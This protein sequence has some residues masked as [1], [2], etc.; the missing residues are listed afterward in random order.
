MSRERF[1]FR[2]FISNDENGWESGAMVAY[3][4][5]DMGIRL[6]GKR[7][8]SKKTSNARTNITT[9]L[10]DTEIKWTGERRGLYHQ[11]PNSIKKYVIG[12]G[13]LMGILCS[14]QYLAD[15][16]PDVYY[17]IAGFLTSTAIFSLASIYLRNKLS[18]R[19][20]II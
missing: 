3:E 1:E 13:I 19:I 8:F 11:F 2:P 15:P 7:N 4:N 18:K 16:Q 14:L 20:K 9:D 5:G 6:F 17:K 12:G 10:G